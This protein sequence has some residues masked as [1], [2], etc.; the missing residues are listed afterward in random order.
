MADILLA[1]NTAVCSDRIFHTKSVNRF[2]RTGIL[3]I[4][5]FGGSPTHDKDFGYLDLQDELLGHHS[6]IEYVPLQ[7]FINLQ[8]V[9]GSTEI[10]IAPLQDNDFTTSKRHGGGKSSSQSWC[11]TTLSRMHE[12]G[13]RR[14][15]EWHLP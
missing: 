5:Y 7:D 13:A 6:R 1:M 10:N 4:G 11:P 9:I 3:S 8:G 15:R 12:S 14:S 2:E